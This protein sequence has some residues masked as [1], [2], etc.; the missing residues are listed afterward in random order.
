MTYRYPVADP[1]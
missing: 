1:S